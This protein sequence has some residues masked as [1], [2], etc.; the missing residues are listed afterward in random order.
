MYRD[1]QEIKTLQVRPLESIAYP[2]YQ[3]SRVISVLVP[4]PITSSTPY[5]VLI[6]WVDQD[7][8]QDLISPLQSNPSECTLIYDSTGTRIFSLGENQLNIPLEEVDQ[9]VKKDTA[10]Y[11]SQIKLGGAD[12]FLAASEQNSTR[13]QCVS[14][15][16]A[17]TLMKSV[18]AMRLNLLLTTL[19]LLA[20]CGFV[21]FLGSRGSVHS[22]RTLENKA[23]L[24]VDADK[25]Y[26]SE[27]DVVHQALDHLGTQTVQLQ[28]R[29]LETIPLIKE[30]LLYAL[31]SGKYKSVEEFN[32][33]AAEAKMR[34]SL[35]QLCVTV[36]RT[37]AK[38]TFD[39]LEYLESLEDALPNVLEGYYVFDFDRQNILFISAS[40][41]PQTVNVYISDICAD[42]NTT[43]HQTLWAAVGP[44]VS[45]ASE[46]MQSYSAAI[47]RI[48]KMTLTGNHGVETCGQT[49][50]P[51]S[52]AM[53]PQNYPISLSVIK[54]D[55]AEIRKNVEEV[56]AFFGSESA[57]PVMI[58][59]LYLNT[60]MTL[61]QG[62]DNM[63]I[64]TQPLYAQAYPSGLHTRK[65]FILLFRNTL[66]KVL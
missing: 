21:A 26:G 16:P 17:D 24:Y 2:E 60:V 19:L 28:Q 40:Q 45:G 7:V 49:E 8:L 37:E 42:V 54:M 5:G 35:H 11:C 4:V 32:A 18:H 22:I 9:L 50:T 57:S 10:A 25:Q 62:L 20:A 47:N 63:D 64:D 3:V 66:K 41:N 14:L 33:D 52:E 46:L 48:D 59:T 43:Q 38:E 53:L 12:Y 27:L 23:R 44:Y 6:F 65:S 39:L 30:R 13:W 31:I 1:L 15:T 61:L 55:A 34:F 29:Y 58:R 56:L 36:L 51:P